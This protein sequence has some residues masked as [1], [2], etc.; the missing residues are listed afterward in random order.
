M[1][2]LNEYHGEGSRMEARLMAGREIYSSV[3]ISWPIVICFAP[4]ARETLTNKAP[5]QQTFHRIPWKLYL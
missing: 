1:G 3:G 5:C 2:F 4:V